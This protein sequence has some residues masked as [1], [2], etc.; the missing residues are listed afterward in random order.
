MSD[1]INPPEC[2]C[3]PD[4]GTP[5]HDHPDCPMRSCLAA[6]TS[7][8]EQFSTPAYPHGD[9]SLMMVEIARLRAEVQ[10]LR[11]DKAMLDW[12][13]STITGTGPSIFLRS[14]FLTTPL[15]D[16][17]ITIDVKTAMPITKPTLRDA[18]RAAMRKEGSDGA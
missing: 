1:D 11:E 7:D 16:T 6:P 15:G 14:I 2:P 9:T 10:A 13:E 17:G 8:P 18:I 4:N 12:L 5:F 3:D